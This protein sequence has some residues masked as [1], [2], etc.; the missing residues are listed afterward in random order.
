M[1]TGGYARRTQGGCTWGKT[2]FFVGSTECGLNRR[3]GRMASRAGRQLKFPAGQACLQAIGVLSCTC[4]VPFS[5]V[6][7][8][9]L[10]VAA[11]IGPTGC[12][13]LR[14]CSNS[15]LALATC[16][17]CFVAPPLAM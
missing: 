3:G 14:I 12:V 13:H 8:C 2:P 16:V 7:V 6:N 5:V 10:C 4:I 15:N 9:C 1:Q 17:E 11:A